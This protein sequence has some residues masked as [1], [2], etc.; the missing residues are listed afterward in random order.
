MSN[1]LKKIKKFFTPTP[2]PTPIPRQTISE[3]VS[4]TP[5]QTP[6][7]P[8]KQTTKHHS[9]SNYDDNTSNLYLYSAF[10]G[11]DCHSGFHGFGDFGHDC[12]GFD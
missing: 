7:Q 4:E 1:I 10:G 12:G 6:K 3:T 9:K 8:T 11:H 5:K 2:T